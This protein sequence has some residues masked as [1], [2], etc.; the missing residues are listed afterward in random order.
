MSALNGKH[1]TTKLNV[2]KL[3]MKLTSSS[4]QYRTSSPRYFPPCRR[5]FSFKISKLRLDIVLDVAHKK[6]ESVSKEVKK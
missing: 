6:Y 2:K 4:L 3:L 5:I 1:S